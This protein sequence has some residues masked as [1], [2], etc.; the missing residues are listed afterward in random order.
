[1]AQTTFCTIFL[2]SM[3]PFPT[4][5]KY[6]N[7]PKNIYDDLHQYKLTW[8]AS[9]IDLDDLQNVISGNTVDF[10]DVL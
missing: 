7:I 10:N 8:I 1:M 5:A 3:K 6:I 9:V 2:F 4:Q